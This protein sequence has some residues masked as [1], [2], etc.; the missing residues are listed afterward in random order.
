MQVGKSYK[1]GNV[2][3]KSFKEITNY[4][5]DG[6]KGASLTTNW[7]FGSVIISIETETDLEILSEAAEEDYFSSEDFSK[8]GLD[9]LDDLVEE[10]WGFEHPEDYEK[11]QTL[12]AQEGE[13]YNS[14]Q[15]FAETKLDFR[16]CEQYFEIEYGG[17][18]IAAA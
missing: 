4:K 10:E 17:V 2:L 11:F 8:V 7:R 14:F 13:R 18:N 12:F 6:D 9:F 16:V 5:Y 15:E 1:V 3:K